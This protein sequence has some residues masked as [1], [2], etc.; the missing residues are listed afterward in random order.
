MKRQRKI[1]D[2]YRD[3]L[4]D[5][6]KRGE[7]KEITKETCLRDSQA[8]LR[9]LIAYFNKSEI[10]KVVKRMYKG[11]YNQIIDDLKELASRSGS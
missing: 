10:K 5:R 9:A 11:N 3:R 2:Q 4:E 1:L 6:V 8:V 7:I